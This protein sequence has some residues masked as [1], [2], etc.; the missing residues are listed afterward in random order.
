MPSQSFCYAVILC[1]QVNI[2]RKAFGE[3][4]SNWA[5][6]IFAYMAP[7][8][9]TALTERNHGKGYMHAL[10]NARPKTAAGKFKRLQESRQPLL[11]NEF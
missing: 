1:L 5:K 10:F 4:V 6:E 2:G 11:K 9:K 8:H 3:D 7:S